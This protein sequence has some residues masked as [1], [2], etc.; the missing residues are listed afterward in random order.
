MKTKRDKASILISKGKIKEALRIL[1]GLDLSYNKDEIRTLSIA[2]ECLTGKESFYKSLGIN[3]KK[4]DMIA[5]EL[6]KRIKR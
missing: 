3:T 4:N 5:K 1:K 2:Y 6:F